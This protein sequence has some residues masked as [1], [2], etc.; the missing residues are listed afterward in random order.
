MQITY[1]KQ[2]TKKPFL[3]ETISNWYKVSKFD[4]QICELDFPIF[5]LRLAVCF[6]DYA[7][8]QKMLKHYYEREIEGGI[9]PLACYTWVDDPDT[10]E[11]RKFL[12]ITENEWTAKDYGTLAHEIHHFV[13]LSLKDIGIDYGEGGEELFAYFQGYVM[14]LVVRAFV[15]LKKTKQTKKK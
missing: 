6:G 3:N 12:L 8:Y 11:K 2:I 14:E 1:E 5:C 4:L 13:H 10:H 9:A 15:E 7:E